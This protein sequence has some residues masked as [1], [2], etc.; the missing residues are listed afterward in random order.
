MVEASALAKAVEAGLYPLHGEDE[1]YDAIVD[2]IGDRPFVLLG[3]ASH[4]THEFY[5]ERVRLTKRLIE[6]RG[7]DA[8]AVEADWPDAYRL[9]RY[10]RGIGRDNDA[11]E[12]LGDFQRFPTWM[13]RNTVV[14]DFVEWLR[15]YNDLTPADVP[16]VGIYGL[17]LYSL[18]SSMAAVVDFLDRVDPEAGRRAR[19]RY[20]CF[21]HFGEDPQIYGY[22][23]GINMSES[24]REEVVEQ[25][26]EVGRLAEQHVRRDGYAAEDEA[27]Y[28]EQNARVA[29]NAE[30]YYR[31]MFAGRDLSWNL[32]DR[33]MADTLDALVK[34]LAKRRANEAKIVVW[35]HNSH[36]G[37]ARATEM[38]ARGELNV[39]QLA[40]ERY[41]RH[42]VLVGFSTY[43]GTVSAASD[44]D[45]PVERKVVRP[46]RPDSYEAVFHE[47]EESNFLMLLGPG[48]PGVNALET[49]RL[50]RAIGVI[51]RPETERVS[52]YFYSR[53]PQQFDAVIHLDETHA[54][55]PLERTGG[56]ER[57]EAPD[58]YPFGL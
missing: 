40:R 34:H 10:V 30:E 5:E 9:N 15:E 44:W 24:C 17:D 42:T 14:R 11:V 56:W 39:G 23:A 3:E 41:G 27:F 26:I 36:I 45:G 12:A 35:E 2:V 57:G 52:H 19:Y 37:D 58:T 22:A 43:S 25:L 32:R 33:H 51:Y 7:F 18:Y 28:A 16:K 8:V 53:L 47:A 55:E 46:A 1:D 54:V 49:P 38:S 29:R 31:S 48:H 4:G 6:E 50:E 13:W 20:S 21:E